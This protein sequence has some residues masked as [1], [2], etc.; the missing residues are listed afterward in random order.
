[1]PSP[2]DPLTRRATAG[3]S[4][5]VRSPPRGRGL[6]FGE[7]A[8]ESWQLTVRSRDEPSQNRT[9]GERASPALASN[10]LKRKASIDK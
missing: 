4:A 1:M 6:F 5:I 7:D 3:E 9:L 10:F 2:T 8:A